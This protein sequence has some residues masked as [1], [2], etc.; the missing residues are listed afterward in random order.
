MKLLHHSQGYSQCTFI[1]REKKN[2]KGMGVGVHSI[3]E[4]LRCIVVKTGVVWHL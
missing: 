4:C 1:Q 3:P 2:N